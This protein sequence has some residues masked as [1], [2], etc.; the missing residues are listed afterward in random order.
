MKITVLGVGNLLTPNLINTSY[1]IEYRVFTHERPNENF[2]VLVDCG[3]NVYPLLVEK[4]R[5]ILNERLNIII[6]HNHPDH[7]GG[8]GSLIYYMHFMNLR[9]K[10][11]KVRIY[12][13]EENYLSLKA[14]LDNTITNLPK[15]DAASL[16][17]L[18]VCPYTII[19]DNFDD[20]IHIKHVPVDHCGMPAYGLAITTGEFKEKHA[21][22][23]GDTDVLNPKSP[24][25]KHADKIFHDVI[26]PLPAPG[27]HA[28]IEDIESHYPDEIKR[29]MILVHHGM[30]I[31]KKSD[32]L[33][34]AHPG[35]IYE[36]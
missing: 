28:Y 17:K 3:F 33:T 36:L 4:Y 13:G 2:Y 23:T 5:H 35:D 20:V 14:I 31:G 9:E 22:I 26:T 21:F 1:L 8:L 16:L 29:K 18:D 19:G 27:A 7:I 15:K 32:T 30:L 34:Y 10:G 12:T 25:I 11:R 24:F 6:T